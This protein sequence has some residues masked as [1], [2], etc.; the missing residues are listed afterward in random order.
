MDT[1][2]L[3]RAH[4]PAEDLAAYV[5]TVARFVPNP[6]R[7]T[8]IPTLAETGANR[9]DKA[10]IVAL[11]G[12]LA[13]DGS[14]V[15]LAR[16]G[17]SDVRDGGRNSLFAH[18]TSGDG[19]Y[20]DGSF[21]QHG[22]VAYTGT[23]GSVLLGGVGQLIALLSGSGWAVTDPRVDVLYEAVDRSFTPVLFDGLMMDAVRGRAISRERAR[24]QR[25]HRPRNG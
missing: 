24:D 17:L 13:R 22:Y 3:L 7:R 20:A 12:L 4:L 6:D 18:V 8:N 16:D 15:A 2:V 5:A 25:L 10:L 14:V 19:F 9:A 23:Y 11:R 1:C 21:V